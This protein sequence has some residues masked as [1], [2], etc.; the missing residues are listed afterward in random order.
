MLKFAGYTKLYEESRDEDRDEEDDRRKHLPAVEEGQTLDLREV[1]PVEHET[2]PPPRFTEAS[3]VK[4]LEE[5]GI[6]RPSTYAT[7]VET[8]QARG[9]ARLARAPLPS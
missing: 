5:K 7:I 8:I 1:A 9:Y 4:T 2:Q 3:L 6:G